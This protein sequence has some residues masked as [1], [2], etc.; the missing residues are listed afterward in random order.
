M[1]FLVYMQGDVVYATVLVS[2]TYRVLKVSTGLLKKGATGNVVFN[3][4][5]AL[6]GIAIIP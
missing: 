4:T 6:E 3:A 5:N 1:N 2:K